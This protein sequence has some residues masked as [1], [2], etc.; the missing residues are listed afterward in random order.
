MATLLSPKS[1]TPTNDYLLVEHKVIKEDKT[2]SGLILDNQ[3]DEFVHEGLVVSTSP[4]NSPLLQKKILFH[5]TD[6][7]LLKAGESQTALQETLYFLVP[8]SRILAFYG[9]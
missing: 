6:G 8:A 1:I 3:N 9:E 2:S 5:M 4:N 7:L